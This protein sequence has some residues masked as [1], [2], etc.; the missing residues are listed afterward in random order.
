MNANRTTSQQQQHLQQQ[1]Q[2]PPPPPPQQQQQQQQPPSSAQF[3]VAAYTSGDSAPAPPQ[4]GA[5]AAVSNATAVRAV[6]STSKAASRSN[7]RRNSINNHSQLNQLHQQHQ[8]HDTPVAVHATS[9]PP[10][11][12][13]AAANNCQHPVG[14]GFQVSAATVQLGHHQQS[15]LADSQRIIGNQMLRRQSLDRAGTFRLAVDHVCCCCCVIGVGAPWQER[16]T[17]RGATYCIVH[18]ICSNTNNSA[19]HTHAVPKEKVSRCC[20]CCR[21]DNHLDR[22]R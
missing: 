22:C 20:C 6:P 4:F 21:V 1:P 5:T 14:R 3:V 15:G 19:W 11:S 12:P 10:A 13:A 8:H 9:A 16:H 2:P 18:R 7:S 17:I